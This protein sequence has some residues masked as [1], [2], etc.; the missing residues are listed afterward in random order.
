MLLSVP[1]GKEATGLAA[2]ADWRAVRAGLVI[3]ASFGLCNLTIREASLS[4]GASGAAERGATTVVAVT[5]LQC[6]ILGAWL[7][8]RE[9]G[10]LKSIIAH[11]KLSALIG[12]TSALG[13]IAWFTAFSM[14]NASY[15]IAVGQIEAV[16][17]LVVSIIYFRERVTRLDLAGIA[18]TMAGVILLRMAG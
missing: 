14:A 9:P 8:R 6:V 10:F 1:V 13:S 18:V 11:R 12:V 3:G 5:A 17:G 16:F 2:Y 4:L 15:V 7:A